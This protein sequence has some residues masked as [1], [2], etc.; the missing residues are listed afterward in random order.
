MARANTFER[1]FAG[2][3][4]RPDAR[5]HYALALDA[6]NPAPSGICSMSAAALFYEA[7]SASPNMA[8]KHP[9]PSS[10]YLGAHT[11]RSGD[12]LD[13]ANYSNAP[14]TRRAILRLLTILGVSR[15]GSV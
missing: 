9:G 8:P 4:Y 11:E 12:W 15:F 14:E 7:V 3:M 10:A 13:G 1:R 2:M 6:D 5:W